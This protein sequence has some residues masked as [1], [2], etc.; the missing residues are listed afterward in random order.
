MTKNSNA[1]MPLY[2]GD[3]L[4]DT[5]MLT[6]DQHGAYLLLI[7]T[8]WRSR[9][10]LPDN[11]EALAMATRSSLQEWKKIRP[12]IERFFQVAKGVWAHKRI[13]EELVRADEKYEAR[14]NASRKA[15]GVRHGVRDGGQSES[16][17]ETNRS[18]NGPPN[19]HRDGSQSHLLPYPSGKGSKGK[20]AAAHWQAA[21]P[22]VSQQP[23]PSLPVDTRW[24][25]QYPKWSKVRAVF[26][27]EVWMR[28]FADCRPNGSETTL[29]C[30]SKFW[31]EKLESQLGDKLEKLFGCPI[32]F[33][34]EDPT[35]EKRQ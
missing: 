25:A 30:R 6:R 2:V 20:R 26:G 9:G 15:N 19:G 22:P 11:D 35:K 16:V 33:K 8:Y 10:P 13:D 12:A 17:T 18:A 1:F 29:I 21:A 4:A 28:M 3:Y 5:T 23:T 27:D 32:T 31:A 14:R 24:E 7:M 34:V